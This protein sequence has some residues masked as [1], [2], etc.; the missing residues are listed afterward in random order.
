MRML[1]CN[2]PSAWRG[3]VEACAACSRLLNADLGSFLP[4]AVTC[5]SR[6]CHH[7]AA[8]GPRGSLGLQSELTGTVHLKALD[9]S[10]CIH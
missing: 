10:G 5:A 2:I 6:V 3:L 9:A 7:A 8:M 1:V 4:E